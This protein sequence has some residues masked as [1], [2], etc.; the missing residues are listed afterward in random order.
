MTELVVGV[1]A[2]G[3]STRALVVAADGTRV[4]RGESGGGNPNSHPPELAA[5]RVAEAIASALGAESGADVRGCMLGVAGESKF[6]DPAV[7]AT[8]EAALRRVGLECPINVVSDAEVAYASA[9]EEPDGTVIVG[10][11]GSVA[12]R[13]VDRRKTTWVGGWGWLLG[14]EGSAYWI[15]REAVRSTLRLLQGTA[16]AGPLA[17][18]VLAEAFGSTEVHLDELVWRRR[19]VNRLIT[20][21]NAEAPIRLARYASM[22]SEHATADAMAVSIVERAAELLAAHA[23]ATRTPGEATPIVL[24]GSVLGPGSPVGAAVRRVL[25][26]EGEVLFTPDC[27]VGAAWLAALV[28]FGPDAPRPQAE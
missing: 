16:D 6:S 22:V 10:G 4:G 14:D 17:L 28:A 5:K 1:D 24:A 21:A 13:I 27:A 12:A 15:G 18:A 25:T 19:A 9:T 8:F 7:V 2:G 11:T 20:A 26:E 3:T 23:V